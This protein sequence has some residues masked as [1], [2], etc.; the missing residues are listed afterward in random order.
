[1]SWASRLDEI[2]H[3]IATTGESA[4][5]DRPVIKSI[6]PDLVCIE[7]I[8]SG[9]G[10]GLDQ[11]MSRHGEALHRFIFRYTNN[12]EDAADI[13]QETFVRIFQKADK[14]KPSAT[15][16]TWMYTIALNLCR[17]L[18][19]RA[20]RIKWLPFLNAP[21]GDGKGL[22]LA[23]TTPARQPDPGDSAA[24]L[25][26]KQAISKG[27]IALPENLRAPFVL[28]VLEGRSQAEA[29]KI[30]DLTTKS[31]EIRVYRARRQLREW[32]RPILRDFGIS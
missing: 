13:T 4:V 14:Y 15:V 24:I 8:R 5:L 30:L 16:K 21:D 18:A 28:C 19:R 10:R 3:P 27:I 29:G 17:D 25:E 32:L 26:L 11:L 22:G 7:Q 23:D 31:V 12:E 6:D 20:A 1:M 2:S 9:D